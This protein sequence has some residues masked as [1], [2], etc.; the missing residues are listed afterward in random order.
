M[1]QFGAA[2]FFLIIVGAKEGGNTCRNNCRKNAVKM[3]FAKV[4]NKKMRP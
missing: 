1:H 2:R 4:V 3:I